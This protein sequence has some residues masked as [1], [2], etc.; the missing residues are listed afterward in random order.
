MPLWRIHRHIGVG[1]DQMVALTAG[2]DAEAR[3]GDAVRAAESEH[4]TELGSEVRALPGAREFIAGLSERGHPIVLASSARQEEV[5]AYLDMLGAR[6]GTQWTT[7]A[8][9]ER[10]KPAPDL[11]EAAL[12]KAGTRDAVLVGDTTWDAEAANRAGIPS[13]GVLTGGF[14]AAELREA[15]VVEVYESVEQLHERLDESPLA[16]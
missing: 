16:R 15:G 8:D 14:G 1:G 13:V 12:E 10:T 3:V 2:E 4:W 7:S 5:E 11:V 6:T 9:V